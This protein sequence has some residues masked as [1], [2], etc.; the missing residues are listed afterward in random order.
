MF[1]YKANIASPTE[2]SVIHHGDEK[3][4]CF[5]LRVFKCKQNWSAEVLLPVLFTWLLCPWLILGFYFCFYVHVPQG[6]VIMWHTSSD[7]VTHIRWWVSHTHTSCWY[8]T[9]LLIVQHTPS[10]AV[11]HT[12]WWCDTPGDG[13]T[14]GDDVKHTW[15]W[16]DKRQM[17]VR[18][19]VWHTPG[20]CV[21][22]NR[23]WWLSLIVVWDDELTL[24][25][26]LCVNKRWYDTG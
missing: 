23:Q 20:D 24:T 5:I 25:R 6:S 17:M 13:V 19:M 4:N 26:W 16:Y 14:P 22:F 7:F 9:H 2:R 11:A 21:T 12:W 3:Q 1:P 8:D 10:D 18:L 15:W